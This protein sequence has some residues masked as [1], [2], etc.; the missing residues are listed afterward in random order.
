M[1]TEVKQMFST[2][3]MN[4]AFQMLRALFRRNSHHEVATTKSRSTVATKARSGAALCLEG[5]AK[6]KPRC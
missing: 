1:A 4:I 6:L 5:R 3:A 2:G